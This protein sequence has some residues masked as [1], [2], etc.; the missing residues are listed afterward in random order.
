MEYPSRSLQRCAET[1]S[2]W[3][4]KCSELHGHKCQP[5]IQSTDRPLGHTLDWVIDTDQ[6]CIVRGNSV[7][8]YVALSYAWNSPVDSSGQTT[9]DS[10]LLQRDTLEQLQRPGF[11]SSESAWERLPQVIQHSIQLVIQTGA[12]YLWVDC[13]C[14]VQNDEGTSAQVALFPRIYSGAYFT[15]IAAAEKNGLYGS[16]AEVQSPVQ[17]NTADDLHGRLLATH[18]ATRGW[19]FQEHVFSKRSIVF[20]DTVIFWD[21]QRS[22]WWSENQS[23]LQLATECESQGIT[24]RLDEE[25]HDM[26]GNLP[27]Q[28]TSF[29]APNL[30]LYREL[31]CRYNHRDLTQPQNAL[32]AFSG[33]L[34]E[35]FHDAFISGLP[36]LILDS[37]LL[38]Q[39]FRKATRRI[40]APSAQCLATESPLPSWSWIGWQCLVDPGSLRSDLDSQV[41]RSFCHY[42]SPMNDNV[43]TNAGSSST[44]FLSK[45]TTCAELRVRRTLIPCSRIK[46]RVEFQSA[47]SVSVFNTSLYKADPEANVL[48]PV[49]TLEDK[50]GRWAGVM[51]L[52]DDDTTVGS[53]QAIE[54]VAISR[55]SCSYWNAAS[56]YEATVDRLGCYKFEPLNGDHYHFE[57]PD[58]GPLDAKACKKILDGSKRETRMPLPITPSPVFFENRLSGR[59]QGP[60]LPL[61][62]Y[63]SHSGREEELPDAWRKTPYEFYNVLWVETKGNVK[64]RKAAGWVSKDVWEET[65]GELEAIVLG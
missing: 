43:S 62:E 19:T 9:T 14:I 41:D 63:D 17:E 39:P 47:L 20:L 1:V 18:W 35:F 42:S 5:S 55:G 16:V 40:A 33:V 53:A 49:A 15:I 22:V 3:E 12:R 54:L 59:D 26:E 52:M 21:C 50:R 2:R 46:P 36:T 51:R 65:C 61:D 29:F 11:L 58:S 48:C 24:S 7:D 28:L 64:Y 25:T 27:R 4:R 45:T 37:L 30:A 60:L 8:K 10:L 57:C 23:S 38:W 31:V 32:P 6:G 44:S 13:L 56:S 34:D